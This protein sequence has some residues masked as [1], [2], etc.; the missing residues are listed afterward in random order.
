MV[1]VV[2]LDAAGIVGIFVGQSE[3][4]V[5]H[6]VKGDFGC[7]GGEREYAD[8]P[9]A[10]AV[11]LRVDDDEHNREFRHLRQGDLKGD[12]VVADQQPAE[13]VGSEPRIEIGVWRRAR[14]A[15]GDRIVRAGL[16]RR[17]V[18]AE[19]IERVR[20]LAER[21]GPGERGHER[22]TGSVEVALLRVGEALGQE[23]DVEGLASGRGAKDLCRA[24]HDAVSGAHR[25]LSGKLAT[26]MAR[27]WTLSRPAPRSAPATIRTT[28]T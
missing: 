17:D 2:G 25:R 8:R 1:L 12:C 24:E 26:S 20:H 21:V 14:A 5:A 28:V 3:G 9:A 7:S 10:P 4:R 18:D 6:L 11:D 15:R 16:V 22:R 13:A 27:G 19:D 23:H